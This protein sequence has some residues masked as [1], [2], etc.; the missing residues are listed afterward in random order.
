MK[1]LLSLLLLLSITAFMSCKKGEMGDMGPAG[2]DGQDGID[3]Q[4]GQNGNANVKSYETTISTADWFF[5]SGNLAS[6]D[7]QV[8]IITE[9]IAATGMV[10]V[11]WH[12]A[13]ADVWFALPYSFSTQIYYFWFKPGLVRIH[14]QN[15]YPAPGTDTEILSGKFRSRCYLF[16]G[17][18]SQS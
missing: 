5:H 13:P 4:N 8:P 18:G 1:N 11:Y 10:M 7:I 6:V 16:S 14:S 2:Q 15:D 3:G 9:Q 17:L 12:Y